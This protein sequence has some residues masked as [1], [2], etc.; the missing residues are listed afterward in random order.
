MYKND[1][2]RKKNLNDFQ[3]IRDLNRELI[4][5]T[6]I[7]FKYIFKETIV[8]NDVLRE[9]TE[10]FVYGNSF[11]TLAQLETS[12]FQDTQM[13]INEFNMFVDDRVRVLIDYQSWIEDARAY[14]SDPDYDEPPKEG[15]LMVMVNEDYSY[16]IFE[17][18]S[19]FRYDYYL[20]FND[21]IIYRI[22][23]KKY[24]VGED[25]LEGFEP[26][27][28]VPAELEMQQEVTNAET[29]TAPDATTPISTDFNLDNLDDLL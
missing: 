14:L 3:L 15:D 17:V 27:S 4:S 6:G 9:S 25:Q 23:L 22:F 29:E 5:I 28:E 26:I 20:Q 19:V 12:A 24:G 18:S 13:M 1:Y 8:N 21:K 7:E 2:F 11:S 10:R 16:D